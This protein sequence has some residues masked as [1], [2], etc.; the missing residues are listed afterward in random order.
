[1]IVSNSVIAGHAAHE[2]PTHPRASP[3]ILA[4]IDG[5]EFAAGK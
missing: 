3:N 2:N 1:M 5:Y 4:K